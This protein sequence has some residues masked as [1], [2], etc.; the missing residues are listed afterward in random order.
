MSWCHLA[1]ISGVDRKFRKSAAAAYSVVALAG[2][3]PERGAADDRV[4]GGRLDV[5]VVGQR[6]DRE[7]ELGLGLDARVARRRLGEQ[8][9]L[10]RAEARSALVAPTA[11]DE[12]A[13]LGPLPEVRD[14]PDL[15]LAVERELG[16][17]APEAVVLRRE[18]HVVVGGRGSR[19]GST[20]ARRSSSG[21]RCRPPSGPRGSR[22]PRPRSSAV[23]SCRRRHPR[24]CPRSCTGRGWSCCRGATASR[25]RSSCSSRRR[26]RGRSTGRTRRRRRP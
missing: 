1:W 14:V 25:R 6:G 10:A 21:S 11:V 5:V 19:G 2:H 3:D 17:D 16:V 18:R 9:A 15:Q 4:L 23:R 24:A 20:T 22:P 12:Q 26:R 8:R 7:V 13:V